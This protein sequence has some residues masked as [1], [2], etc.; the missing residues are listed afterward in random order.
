MSAAERNL[1]SVCLFMDDDA[2]RLLGISLKNHTNL[3]YKHDHQLRLQMQYPGE[4]RASGIA[5]M[6]S[7][8]MSLN[9]LIC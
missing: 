5:R 3:K 6:K 1:L 9:L 4:V 7:S 2:D 8:S